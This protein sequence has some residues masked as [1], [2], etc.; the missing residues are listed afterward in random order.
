MR[1]FTLCWIV[2]LEPIYKEPESAYEPE[3]TYK[4]SEPIYEPEPEPAPEP[5]YKEPEPAYEPEPTYKEPE[6]EYEP[7]PTYKEP[8][9]EYEPEP[10]YKEP[11]PEY[12]P[13]YV[14]EPSYPPAPVYV[15]APSYRGNNNLENY[16]LLAYS[17]KTTLLFSISIWSNSCCSAWTKYKTEIVSNF[18]GSKKSLY[19]QWTSL[20]R[21]IEFWRL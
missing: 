6:P 17:S 3:P 8:E 4:E 15:P 12:E 1:S 18:L 2:A 16:S 9:P 13:T 14:P 20:F 10:T 21:F 19:E 7:E 11:E 5:I